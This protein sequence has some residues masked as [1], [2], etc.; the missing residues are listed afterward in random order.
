MLYI[1]IN[2]W[3]I[4]E[5]GII[6]FWECIVEV[7]PVVAI[8]LEMESFALGIKSALVAG[9]FLR[10]RE[11]GIDIIRAFYIDLHDTLVLHPSAARKC[12]Q[13]PIKSSFFVFV[14]ENVISQT[15]FDDILRFCMFSGHVS[16]SQTSC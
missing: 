15:I 10:I 16:S 2:K 12:Q 7:T 1:I 8:I 13:C 6:H 9:S 4:F 14:S 11:V 3:L 5:I